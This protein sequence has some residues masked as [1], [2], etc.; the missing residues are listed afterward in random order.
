LLAIDLVL[1]HHTITDIGAGVS[2]VVGSVYVPSVAVLA[3]VLLRERPSLR[4]LIT[5]P[6]VL[7][8]IVLASGIIGGSGTGHHPAAGMA[9]GVVA[10]F[11]YAAIC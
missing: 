1:F 9:Y 7:A 8:G 6:V 5:L 10:N 3:W 2:T 4:Y 11:A